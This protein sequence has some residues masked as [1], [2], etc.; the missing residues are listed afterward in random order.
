[1][2]TGTSPRLGS[3]TVR[4]GSLEV[5]VAGAT[6]LLG[7]VICRRLA[8]HGDSVRALVRSG[9]SPSVRD[10]LRAAGVA[11]MEGDLEQPETLARC[12]DGIDV[13]VSTASSFPH[14]PRALGDAAEAA[15]V[16]RVV[17][18]SFPPAALDSPFQRAKREIE[19]RLRVANLEY[20]ILQPGNFMD[21][22]FTQD[23]GL[24]IASRSMRLYGGG[25]SPLSWITVADLAA[26]AVRAVRDE[27]Y[28]AATVAF[29]NGEALS[30]S[31]VLEIVERLS[32][33]SFERVEVPASELEK[34]RVAATN[35]TEESIACI[36]LDVIEPSILPSPPGIASALV[37]VEQFVAESL[38]A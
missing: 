31:A 34:M 11:E 5:L 9:A 32:G 37:T 14:D 16:Q 23:L 30:Q 19:E 8:K 18:I 3:S 21:V 25:V 33:E 22:W 2:D 13:I 4:G 27:T 15:G 26:V 38:L 7:S 17:Y 28:T 36:L 12:L 20:S 29:G 24:D 10:G 6:G 35:P 1:M